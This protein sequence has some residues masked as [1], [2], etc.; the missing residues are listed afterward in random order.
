MNCQFE[1]SKTDLDFFGLLWLILN[2]QLHYIMVSTVVKLLN[3][4]DLTFKL[5]VS[6]Q[7]SKEGKKIERNKLKDI[8]S[9]QLYLIGLK[10]KISAIYAKAQRQQPQM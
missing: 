9:M 4:P 6:R 7:N 2:F 3:A 10:F 5:G 8:I 1:S